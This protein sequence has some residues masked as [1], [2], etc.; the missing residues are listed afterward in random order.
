MSAQVFLQLVVNGIMLGGVYGLMSL[1]IN[2][3]WGV[4]NAVLYARLVP[5]R[6]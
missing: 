2:L 3:V 6:R 1:G 5:L 4:V